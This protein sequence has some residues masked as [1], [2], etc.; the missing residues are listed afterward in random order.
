M[1]KMIK[2][3]MAMSMIHAIREK[4][5]ETMKNL[6]NREKRELIAAKVAE[7]MKKIEQTKNNRMK[8]S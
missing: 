2:D 8:A 6:S 1:I 4:H 5:Y 3:S 7:A